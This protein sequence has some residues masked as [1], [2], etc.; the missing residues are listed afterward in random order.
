MAG[1][2]VTL[3]GRHIWERLGL[4]VVN[5]RLVR[6]RKCYCCGATKTVRY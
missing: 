6:R 3:N 5:G 2:C 1:K 4:D